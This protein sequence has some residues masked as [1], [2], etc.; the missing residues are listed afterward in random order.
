MKAY[1]LLEN[2]FKIQGDLFGQTANMLGEL[3]LSSEGTFVMNCEASNAQCVLTQTSASLKEGNSAFFSADIQSAKA[4]LNDVVPTYGK[5]VVDG[6]G[7]EYHMYDLKTYI[8]G[9]ELKKI[10]SSSAKKEAA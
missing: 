9:I 10:Q 4:L 8:P 5:L 2:G 6:L 7:E 1:L 3:I